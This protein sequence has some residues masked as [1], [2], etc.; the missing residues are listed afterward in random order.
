MSAQLA[1]LE[2]QLQWAVS[3]GAISLSEAWALQDLVSLSPPGMLE[4]P[5]S[6]QPMLGRMWLLEQ[7]PA[8]E[9]P[10]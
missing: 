7:E 5:E 10:L 4:M 9:L 8:N 2:P 1:V 6:L 3:Q